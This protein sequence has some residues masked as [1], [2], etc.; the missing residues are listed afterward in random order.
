M[1]AFTNI[2]KIE[3]VRPEVSN[4][5]NDWPSALRALDSF[6]AV[7]PLN[8]NNRSHH[9]HIHSQPLNKN[10]CSH[11]IHSHHIPSQSLNKNNRSHDIHSHPPR[12]EN[13]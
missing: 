9:H 1:N 5:L 3:S 10:N 13:A 2:D 4:W 7:Q 12:P 11:N 8:K 6:T